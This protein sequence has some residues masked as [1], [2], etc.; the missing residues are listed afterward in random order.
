MRL[1][2]CRV[3]RYPIRPRLADFGF[4]GEAI[5]RV[6]GG[7]ES[8][9]ETL[10]ANKQG[11]LDTSLESSPV[12]AAL[13]RLC[14]TQ[15]P[16][17]VFNGNY[18]KLFERLEQYRASNRVGWPNSP[19][20]LANTLR[21]HFS[22][23][24]QVGIRVVDSGKGRGGK[25]VTVELLSSDKPSHSSQSSQTPLIGATARDECDDC[26]GLKKDVG[27]GEWDEGSL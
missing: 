19:A 2:C 14:E 12:C 25:V 15:R 3:C 18:S 10:Q 23:L 13:M 24:I 8:F 26:D 7:K 9:C 20:G 22:G 1:Q 6:L 5:A 27:T 4:M 21:R 17:V 11:M 16:G